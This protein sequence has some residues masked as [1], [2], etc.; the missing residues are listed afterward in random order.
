M[1]VNRPLL[2][3]RY[4]QLDFFVCDILNAAPKDELGSMEHPVFTLS[5]KPDTRIRRY[6]HNGSKI[7]II[8]SALGF[9]TIFDK[10][11][12]IYCISQVM[13]GINRDRE[14]SR[15]LRITAYDLLVFTNR[16]TDGDSYER[17]KL[18]LDRLAGTRIKTNIKT[19]GAS[20]R[21][22][23]GII[24]RYQ[25]VEK[26]PMNQQMVAIEITLSEWTYNSIIAREVLG[27]HGNYFRLRKAIDRRLYEL[28][29]KHCGRQ[30]EWKVSVEVLYKK[31]GSDGSIRNFRRMLKQ[32][33][34]SNH[35]PSYKLTYDSLHQVVIFTNR[36]KQGIAK[37]ALERL[38]NL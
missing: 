32:I 9:A 10:D 13:E 17:L 8:P 28:A 5:T 37:D 35:L 21:Q 33:A 7:E 18:A 38:L 26:L 16:A 24:D 30:T 11:I 12:L 34:Q 19:G 22:N 20:I 29:R 1:T 4:R 36:D 23:F 25:I 3:E 31:S 14:V 15:T 6:E 27:I 2:P